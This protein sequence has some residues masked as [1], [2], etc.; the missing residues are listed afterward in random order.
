M[1][2]KASVHRF[3]VPRSSPVAGFAPRRLEIQANHGP[4]W[5]ASR[6][7]GEAGVVVRRL[8][9]EPHRV[10]LGWI[11]L[12]NRIG[13]DDS[14]AVLASV[15]DCALE[16]R[17]SHALAAMLGRDDEADDG[18]DGLVVDRL[19]HRRALESGEFFARRER[20]PSYGHA[21]AVSDE[22]RRLAGVD[23]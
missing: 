23:K 1:S 17:T 8:R 5:F 7:F 3:F 12:I 20:D 19:H 15:R 18:P 21:V 11:G 6:H 16:Q 9:S 2:L 14:G 10:V 13:L 22:P 4:R